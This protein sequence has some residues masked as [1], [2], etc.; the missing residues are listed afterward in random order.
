MPKTSIYL[1]D[2]QHAFLKEHGLTMTRSFF[3]WPDFMPGPRD[4]DDK[5]TA[6]FKDF[7]DEVSP[8]DFASE[9]G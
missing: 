3:Y 4:I 5:M 1:S 7:L 9:E 2:A 8:E 6:R